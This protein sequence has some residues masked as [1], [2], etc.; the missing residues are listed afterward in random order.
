MQLT[1]GGGGSK[2]EGRKEKLRVKNERLGGQRARR[3]Q[4]EDIKRK[5][6][7]RSANGPAL[8]GGVESV[9]SNAEKRKDA[10][11]NGEIHPSRKPQMK[12]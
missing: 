8:T 11:G 1:A 7:G 6:A 12:L 4:A 5:K 9:A 2:S 3:A 10:V